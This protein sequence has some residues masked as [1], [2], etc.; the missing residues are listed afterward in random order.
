M[1]DCF[2]LTYLFLCSLYVPSFVA[3]KFYYWV[4]ECSSIIIVLLFHIAILYVNNYRVKVAF[5][6][7]NLYG[8]KAIIR[9]YWEHKFE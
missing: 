8:Q 1:F 6:H 3:D 9:C 2:F 5:I 4:S 7:I